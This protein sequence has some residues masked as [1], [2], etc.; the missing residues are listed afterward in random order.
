MGL[1]EIKL[2]VEKAVSSAVEETVPNPEK[3][4]QE[5]KAKA[6]KHFRAP[7]DKKSSEDIDGICDK[8]IKLYS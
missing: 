2:L 3:D 6:L 5:R 4:R 7:K 1:I 8:L